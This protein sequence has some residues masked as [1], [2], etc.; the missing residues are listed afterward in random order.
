M[1]RALIIILL[2]I[3]VISC[4]SNYRIEEA[5]YECL[6]EGFEDDG[7]DLSKKME[8]IE[9]ELLDNT[10]LPAADGEGYDQMLMK[11]SKKKNPIGMSHELEKSL[12]SLIS[13]GRRSDLRC[14][15]LDLA[16]DTTGMSKCKFKLVEYKMIEF[17]NQ[18]SRDVVFSVMSEVIEPEDMDQPFYKIWVFYTLIALHLNQ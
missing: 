3:T 14:H 7:V 6:D 18:P 9:L 2:G 16:I 5:M 17:E 12:E 1:I 13:S 10:I 11:L 8:N 4:S 15:P